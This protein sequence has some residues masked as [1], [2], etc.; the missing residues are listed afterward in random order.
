VGFGQR[1]GDLPGPPGLQAAGAEFGD[2]AA[3]AQDVLVMTAPY[4]GFVIFDPVF[5]QVELLWTCLYEKSR[6]SRRG[7][8]GI[9]GSSAVCVVVGC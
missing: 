8:V 3:A 5:V 1:F 9:A 4:L 2:P 7:W 6:E